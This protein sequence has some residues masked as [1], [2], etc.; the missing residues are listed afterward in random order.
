MNV[1]SGI[2]PLSAL[3]VLPVLF[4]LAACS[5]GGGGKAETLS[6]NPPAPSDGA[7]DN[8]TH[9]AAILA[10]GFLQVIGSS[11]TSVSLRWQDGQPALLVAGYDVYQNEQLIASVVGSVFSYSV[12]GL[13]AGQE[14][15]FSVRAFDHQGQR[16][17]PVSI[18]ASP[19]VN[20]SPQFKTPSRQ[21]LV[22]SDTPVGEL[23]ASFSA[24]DADGDALRFNVGSGNEA[25]YFVLDPVSGELRT[26]TSLANL[27]GKVFHLRVDV[28][29]SYSVA[30]VDLQLGVVA[31]QAPAEQQALLRQVYRY[32]GINNKLASLYN[33]PQYPAT[34]SSVSEEKSFMSP[35]NVADDYGQRM[36]G[37]LVPQV[38]GDYVFWL[39]SDD[40]G[41]LYLGDA[42][43]G[44]DARLIA[45]VASNSSA[46][47]WDKSASQKSG[48]ITLQAGRAYYI[49]ATMA[50]GSGSDHLAVAWQG[51]GLARQII[52]GEYLRLP[53]DMTAPDMPTGLNAVRTAENAILLEWKPATDDHA[54]VAYRI[55]NGATLLGNAGIDPDTGLVQTYVQLTDLASGSRY[56]FNV[57]AVD[58]AGNIS[59]ASQ[60]YSVMIND[61]IAPSVP[62]A[63]Q[64]LS[65]S[66][67]QIRIN[68]VASTD[69][70]NN[71]VLYRIYLNGQQVGST[72][73]TAFTLTDL[74]A[75]TD[76]NLQVEALDPV[77]N[78]SQSEMLVVHTSARDG[79]KPYFSAAQYNIA[80]SGSAQAGTRVAQFNAQDPRNN[81]LTYRIVAGN[82]AANFSLDSSATLSLNKAFT[83]NPPQQLLL[84]IE[85]DNGAQTAQTQVVVNVLSATVLSHKGLYRE[86]WTGISGNTVA[87]INTT[88]NPSQQDLLTQFETPSS[89]GDS[90][91]QRLRAYLIPPTSGEYT[92]WI[93]SDDASE[94]YLSSDMSAEKKELVA[95]ISSYTS[96]HNW[97]N[98]NLIKRNITLQAGQLYYIEAL[99]KEGGGSDHLSVAWQGPGIT[100]QLISGDYLLSYSALTPAAPILNS[101]VQTGFDQ[102][103]NQL[104]VQLS[105]SELAAG[106]PVRIYYGLRDGGVNAVEWQSMLNVGK[107]AAGN[108][109]V[110]LDDIQAGQTYYVRVESE[111]GL[112]STWSASALEV[113]TV[114]VSADKHAGHS[115]PDTLA[116]DV[117]INGEIQQVA[118]NKHSVRSPNFQF[119]TFDD[120]RQNQFEAVSPM[121]EPRTY[122]GS[123]V[124]NPYVVVTGVVDAEGMLYLSGW[125][126]QGRAWGKDVNISDLIDPQALGNT[127]IDTEE[128]LIDFEIPAAEGNQLYIPQPGA[129]FHNNLARTK[130]SQSY[131]QFTSKSKSNVLNALAQ[132]E[133]QINELDYVWAQKTGLR[134]DIAEGLIEMHGTTKASSAV[135]PSA[136][137][138]GNFTISLQDP[139]N[140]GQCWGGGDWV[141]CE[142]SYRMNWGFTH[143][144]GHN[145]GLGHGE[146]ED[147]SNQIQTPGTQMGN[148]Q[149]RNTLMRLQKGSKFKPAKAMEDPMPPAAFKDYVTVYRNESASIYPLANDYDVNGEI[150]S[151][152]SFDATTAAG[153]TVTKT[154]NTLRYTPPT[155]FVGNDQ[156]SYTV[157]DGS[158]KTVGAIQIQ[159][160]LAGL[161]GDWRMDNVDG[162]RVLDASGQGNDLYAYNAVVA[163]AQTTGISGYGMAMPLIASKE[164]VNDAIG[165]KLLP[166]TLEPGHKSFTASIW[167][168][169][170]G[171]DGNKLIVGKAS[172]GAGN[173]SY[174]GWQIRTE[175]DDLVMQITYR[176]RLLK[177]NSV[178]IRQD[179]SIID[180]QWHHAVM[181]VDQENGMLRGYLDG[182][183]FDVQGTLLADGG[184]ILAAMNFT[185]YGGG[186]PFKVGGFT[187]PVCDSNGENCATPAGNVY[188]SVRVYHRALSETEVQNLP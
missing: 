175:G 67:S 119:I 79:Q 14:Y 93:A 107:L 86:L 113:T 172:S 130:I 151:I 44:S 40:Q 122:R 170:S 141:G 124:N 104:M 18:S 153:G 165:Q 114:L 10:P 106:F 102:Q 16:S 28:S 118:L 51:P 127:E 99:H 25:D 148:M 168:Q 149:S 17:A 36:F 105:I 103:G 132:M 2:K 182:H 66:D 143:E 176:N 164:G 52:A 33:H 101:V 162:E 69:E 186:T 147:N 135:K 58:A 70:T 39:A 71:A 183:P 4:G 138:A 128:L 137:D 15:L 6:V 180:G 26:K 187:E 90:Y 32:S 54:V 89:L 157:S 178:T 87:D 43:D 60:P 45:S 84:T 1:I 7:V 160:Q 47:Q 3:L 156:L 98:S 13:N 57:R 96:I 171:I 34:P 146:Q 133:G 61:I 22:N 29:D 73:D 49:R 56:D 46:Q 20:Q 136:K 140:G 37:Y 35:S 145:F 77:G 11:P 55:Y 115:L 167:F 23:L 159:V 131:S 78:S 95:K 150:L 158:N 139:R 88:K 169:Y 166:H 64:A 24:T 177:S 117:D 154:G 129:D 75:D 80:V 63:L 68:W 5:G 163:D 121:P 174:G 19:R 123:V 27:G 92:F 155:D 82:E 120:R 85:A 97:L 142:S 125:T 41:E 62:T 179:N 91:G 21:Q 184:P 94:L 72:Y 188:D 48:V 31:I 8:D 126:G 74:T 152:A 134:F 181:V 42:L 144:I 76:F 65:V 110:V 185:H 116:L 9:G 111:G 81:V 100:Q 108:H 112:A 161:V 50:E 12:T 53:V 83:Q 59:A 173:M 30:S 109:T 38:S